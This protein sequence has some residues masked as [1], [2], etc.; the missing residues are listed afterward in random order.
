VYKFYFLFKITDY[1]TLIQTFYLYKYA[2]IFDTAYL[3]NSC[4]EQIISVIQFLIS[5]F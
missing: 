1:I 2:M 4:F 5:K 3:L